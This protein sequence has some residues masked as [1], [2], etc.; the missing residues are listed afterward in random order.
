MVIPRFTEDQVKFKF[1]QLI[2]IGSLLFFR[3]TN[4][5]GDKPE[6]ESLIVEARYDFYKLICL[7]INQNQ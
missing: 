7:S 2:S 5:P 6:L 4:P 1:K 3:K